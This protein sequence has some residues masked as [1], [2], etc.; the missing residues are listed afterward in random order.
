MA[1]RCRNATRRRSSSVNKVAPLTTC[2]KEKQRSVIRFLSSEGVKPIEIHRRM[3]VQYGDACLSLQQVYE[4]TRKFMNDISFV[5]DSPRPDQ[6]HQVVKSEA[7]AAVKAI[8][9]ENRH[10]TVNEIAAHPDMSHAS[11]HHIVHE[12]NE[13][14]LR[15]SI[16]SPSYVQYT[17][18]Q[19]ISPCEKGLFARV[20]PCS[21]ILFIHPS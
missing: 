10:V 17:T 4:W 1:V 21:E 18:V 15:F 2:T 14:Y 16:D 12:K 13:K 19:G 3:K 20:L 7:I 9:K 8:V 6:A 5:T 11:A